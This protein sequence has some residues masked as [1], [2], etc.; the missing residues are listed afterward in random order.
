MKTKDITDEMRQDII[1]YTKESLLKLGIDVDVTLK[2]ITN[3]KGEVYL[4]IET[5]KFNTTP[6]IYKSIKVNG[7]SPLCHIEDEDRDDVYDL[8]FS[9]YYD[10][11]YFGGASNGVRIGFLN[12]RVFEK[13]MRVAFLGLTI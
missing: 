11:E 8:S 3:C 9:L 13:S 12:F 10:F 5:S 6:V 7:S 1:N 2:E 4:R